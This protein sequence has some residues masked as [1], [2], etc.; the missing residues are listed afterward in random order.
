MSASLEYA[1]GTAHAIAGGSLYSGH[2]L[3]WCVSEGVGLLHWMAE[4]PTET[5]VLLGRALL[6]L[7][8]SHKQEQKR[9]R[10]AVEAGDGDSRDGLED[11]RDS[12]AASVSELETAFRELGVDGGLP[13]QSDAVAK[14][15][16]AART[17]AF[18]S[19]EYRIG[20]AF[21]PLEP[22]VLFN[23][24]DFEWQTSDGRWHRTAS[25]AGMLIP[26]VIVTSMLRDASEV[27]TSLF[28]STIGAGPFDEMEAHLRHAYINHGQEQGADLR[29][30]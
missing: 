18:P 4:R 16:Q 30:R 6:L 5:R 25:V 12:H 24:L 13:R 27:A 26:L 28:E 9:A 10:L 15:H 22:L 8:D 7:I 29:L 19:M 21:T 3:E 23:S 17:S 20:S 1:E 2:A 14:V 11:L